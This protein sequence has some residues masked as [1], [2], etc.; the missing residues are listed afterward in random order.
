MESVEWPKLRTQ[1]VETTGEM[2]TVAQDG[3]T[4]FGDMF[5]EI[6]QKHVDNVKMWMKWKL[7]LGF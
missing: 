4:A 7:K 2:A 5:E 3:D 1:I 6:V